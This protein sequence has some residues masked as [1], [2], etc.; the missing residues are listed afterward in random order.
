[1]KILI[2]SA[3][4]IYPGTPLNGETADILVESGIIKAIK[5]NIKPGGIKTVIEQDDLHVSPGWFDMQAHFCD[6]GYEYKEDIRSGMEAAAHGG[7]TGVALS[8]ATHP[9]VYSKSQ[10]EYILGKADGNLVDVFPVGAL[11]HKME[12]KELSE[13]YDMKL[14]GAVAFSDDTNSVMDSGLMY[15]A[16]LYS[17][18]FGGLIMSRCNDRHVSSGTFVNEG[19]AGVM[20]GM[21]GEPSIAEE[22][23]VVRDLFLADNTASRLHIHSISTAGSAELVRNA[24]KRGLP[25]TASVNAFNLALDE[26]ALLG[27]DSFYKVNPPLRS[28]DD[29]KALRNALRDG[30][31]DVICSDHRPEDE[32]NKKL[33]FDLAAPG[34]T[35]IQ[36]LYPLVNMY[37]GL[38]TSQII[39][40]IALAPRRILGLPL[41][42]I[43]EGK[44][45]NLTVFS[46]G[47]EWVLEES[48]LKSRSKNTPWL[49]KELKGKAIAVI[50]NGQLFSEPN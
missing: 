5:K 30:V 31:I 36:T 50:N 45:A 23:M 32:E 8:P 22:I 2:K 40:K 9:P 14:S 48:R 6:P 33:E 44:K 39:E 41:P 28:K 26:T 3:K 35:G 34:I 20:M 16:L 18:S 43:E 15:R 42:E 27:F 37:S 10:V 17:K 12:G 7:F 4:I 21:K 13:M 38:S 1:M 19:S 47:A 29:I 49:G 25:V 11:S 46:P 24:R